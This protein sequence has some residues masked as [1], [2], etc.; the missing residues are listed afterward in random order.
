M[1]ETTGRKARKTANR[2]AKKSGTETAARGV[3]R[4]DKA[5]GP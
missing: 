1:T 2:S 3:S 4:T 5:S